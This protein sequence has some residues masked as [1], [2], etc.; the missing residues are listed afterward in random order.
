[1]EQNGV[2]VTT[3]GA[4]TVGL[5]AGS[6]SASVGIGSAVCPAAVEPAG[7]QPVRLMKQIN[8]K[9]TRNLDVLVLV[10][11]GIIR[12]RPFPGSFLSTGISAVVPDR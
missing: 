10:S 4:G 5:A 2:A 3:D 7:V 8:K 9:D 11:N 6:P 1:L 12:M